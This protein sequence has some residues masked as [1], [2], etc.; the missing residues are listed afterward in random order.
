MDALP[1]IGTTW[2]EPSHTIVADLTWSG[3]ACGHPLIAIIGV[4]IAL[5]VKK[6]LEEHDIPGKIV[7]LGTPG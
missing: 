6:A 5:A 1:G 3:H 2:S 4:G 7:L